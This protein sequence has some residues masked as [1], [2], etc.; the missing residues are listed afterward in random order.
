MTQH[1][2]YNKKYVIYCHK[3]SV[4]MEF[5]TESILLINKL[6]WT[7]TYYIINNFFRYIVYI[8]GIENVSIYNKCEILSLFMSFK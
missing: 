5:S 8:H 4:T 6:V 2:F 1:K 7:I 3:Y